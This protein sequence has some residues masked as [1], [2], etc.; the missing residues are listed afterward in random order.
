MFAECTTPTERR[1]NKSERMNLQ[2]ILIGAPLNGWKSSETRTCPLSH[3]CNL[4][5][6]DRLDYIL[7]LD[8]D[9]LQAMAEHHDRC[10]A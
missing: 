5:I 7:S 4:A 10:L 1:L 2:C 6:E 8:D 9:D 3:L